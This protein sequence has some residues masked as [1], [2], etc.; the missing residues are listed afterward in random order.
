MKH[1]LSQILPKVPKHKTV[2]TGPALVKGEM[3]S[4]EPSLL[5]SLSHPTT[6]VP[7]DFGAALHKKYYP[8][9]PHVPNGD[10]EIQR[11][12]D[13]ILMNYICTNTVSQ[14]GHIL[15]FWAWGLQHMNWGVEAGVGGHNSI[16]S[17]ASCPVWMKI[18]VKPRKSLIPGP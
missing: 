9:T 14:Q 6:S 15:R 2:K 10:T 13:L 12:Y 16:H 1:F 5:N 8:A 3:E 7:T 11:E 18:F 4:S 17:T